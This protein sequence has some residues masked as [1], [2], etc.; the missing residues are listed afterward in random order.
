MF[1]A[2]KLA[3]TLAGMAVIPS[4][5]FSPLYATKGAERVSVRSFALDTEPVTRGEFLEFVRARS[6]WRRTNLKTSGYLAEWSN[7]LNAGS[8]GDLRRPVTSVSRLA[9]RAY[10]EWK[11]KRLPSAAEWEYAAAANEKRRDASHE[12]GAIAKLVGFYTHRAA[13]PGVIGAGARN[14]YGL[15]DM[16]ELVWEWT[17]TEHSMHAGHMF[18]ASSA[19]G[20]SDPS[21]YPAFMRYAVRSALNDRSTLK[22]LGFRCAANV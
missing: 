21:N 9:A 17:E 12:K 2:V 8:R 16:H 11:G 7:D 3:L 20:A 14:V 19:I 1:A 15:R 6:E 22:T 5:T 10:C 13:Q 4:G 18:C